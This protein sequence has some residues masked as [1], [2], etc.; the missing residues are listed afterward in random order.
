MH[1]LSP[2]TGILE[3]NNTHISLKVDT[4]VDYL[5]DGALVT[6]RSLDNGD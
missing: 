4:T 5:C 1:N 3:K 2:S 6:F